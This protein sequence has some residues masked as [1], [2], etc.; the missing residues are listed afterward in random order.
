MIY[1]PG[2]ALALSAFWF[3]LSGE[4]SVM[5]LSFFAV[6]L[7]AS[8]WLAAR[9]EII[10]RDASPWLRLPQMLLYI[11]WLIVEVLKAN[12]SVIRIVMTPWRPVSP[13][14]TRVRFSGRTDLAK[15]LFAN[16]ITLTPGTV[17]V[18]V[19]GASVFLVHALKHE[20]AQPEAFAEMDRRAARA[21]DG[22]A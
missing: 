17:T 21:A 10:D 2:L 6:S 9:L 3:A 11:P 7:L 20:N 5:F 22:K 12:L 15:A 16:S 19:E 13:A 1:L 18:D 14:M 4:T 8:L